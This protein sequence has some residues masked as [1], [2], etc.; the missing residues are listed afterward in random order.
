MKAVRCR[1]VSG[2]EYACAK[3]CDDIHDDNMQMVVIDVPSSAVV[4]SPKGM[5]EGL[6]LKT[7]LARKHLLL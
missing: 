1:P 6:R 4:S 5:L 3:A 7:D 2:T